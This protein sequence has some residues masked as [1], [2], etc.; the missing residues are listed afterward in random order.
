M[1]L[2]PLEDI[3]DFNEAQLKEWQNSISEAFPSNSEEKWALKANRVLELIQTELDERVSINQISFFCMKELTS[4]LYQE[5]VSE[6]TTA[7]EAPE[8]PEYAEKL[9]NARKL[10]KSKN[11]REFLKS[12]LK[13]TS[14]GK[15]LVIGSSSVSQ[16]KKEFLKTDSGKPPR[17]SKKTSTELKAKSV[18]KPLKRNTTPQR[19]PQQIPRVSSTA[20]QKRVIEPKKAKELPKVDLT[21][22]LQ[23]PTKATHPEKTQELRAKKT[24]GA[25]ESKKHIASEKKVEDINNK[26]QNSKEETVQKHQEPIRNYTE[27]SQVVQE[28]LE[29]SKECCVEN[30]ILEK[31]CIPEELFEESYASQELPISQKHQ[32]PQRQVIQEIQVLEEPT[33]YQVI[34]KPKIPQSQVIQEPE[35]PQ[36]QVIQE[37]EIPKTRVIEEPK[38]PQ[39]QVIQEPEIPQ[40]RVIEEPEIPQSQVIQEPEIPKTRVIEEPKIPQELQKPTQQVTSE[41]TTIEQLNSSEQKSVAELQIPKK[42]HKS[43]ENKKNLTLPKQE[44]IQEKPTLITQTHT[45]PKKQDFTELESIPE[46]PSKQLQN[47]KPTKKPL[48]KP[49]KSTKDSQDYSDIYTNF[50]E[51]FSGFRVSKDFSLNYVIKETISI[52]K[53]FQSL[54]SSPEFEFQRKFRLSLAPLELNPRD[55]LNGNQPDLTK[56]I[57]SSDQEKYYRVV[58]ARSEVYDIV[59][60][61]F[62]KKKGWSELPH[63]LNLKASWNMMWTWS[64]PRL[65][66]SKLLAWQKVNHFPETRNFSRKDLLK[67]NIEKIQKTS[68][69]CWQAWNILP[70]TFALPKEYLNFVDAFSSQEQ[71][72]PQRNIWIMKPIGKSR[73]RGIQVVKDLNQVTYGEPIIIQKYITDPILL[74]GYKFD[75]R[76][77][78]LITSFSPLEVFLYHEGFARM[79]TV[80]FTLNPEKLKNKF[81]H[82]TNSSIQKHSHSSGDQ[83]ESFF[84]GTKISLKTLKEKLGR[85]FDWEGVWVQVKEVV[86]KSLIAVQNEIPSY[87]C[88]FDLVGYDMI[89]DTAGK[90]WLIEINSSPSLARDNLLDDMIKQQLIDDTLEI[91]EPIYYNKQE[92]LK[93][94]E[95]RI[96]ELNKGQNFNSVAQMNEDLSKILEGRKPRKLGE[97]PQSIGNY[98]L[99]APSQ[100]L[101]R[102]YKQANPRSVK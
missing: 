88:C 76:L 10:Q 94:L 55:L 27:E 80:R 86:L 91:V 47:K 2:P 51:I 15:G 42:H 62:N 35:I 95:R 61:S 22:N 38:I 32:I 30:A 53:E 48:K 83:V 16:A 82:L 49:S 24:Q 64:K 99:I 37:P 79:S 36:S 56:P 14:V 21:Q 17:I 20:K 26:V 43:S 4:D 33:Q 3:Y 98:E 45:E 93:V 60:R 74:D 71:S 31:P 67:K 96:S 11:Y 6:E 46:E 13:Q 97:L 40:T 12:T 5:V 29:E 8:E 72:D 63:G 59:T 68:A 7:S 85:S 102:L 92:L 84:G 23:K 1:E 57:G 25:Q 78:V 77:Y 81:I 87:S 54:L 44:T 9:W 34:E 100:M 89:I 69:K 39:S 41:E 101:D 18:D 65:D 52:L 19:N 70:P 66:M 75:L 90:V 50:N 58:R 73:G 28:S